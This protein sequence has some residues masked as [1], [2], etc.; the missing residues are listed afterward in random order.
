MHLGLQRFGL[1]RTRIDAGGRLPARVA[2]C[3]RPDHGAGRRRVIRSFFPLSGR[4]FFRR[5][6]RR[7]HG[8]QCR[9]DR[10]GIDHRWCGRRQ[11]PG[12][13]LRRMDGHG[14][15]LIAVH[16][17]ADGKVAGRSDGQRAG[18]AAGRT[19]RSSRLGASR[20]R[21]DQ[22]RR[23]RLRGREQVKTFK[24][25]QAWQISEGT[26]RRKS[27]AG[28]HKGDEAMQIHGSMLGADECAPPVS[29]AYEGKSRPRSRS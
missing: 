2:G 18:R 7:R 23:R 15:R 8:Q 17:I 5:R 25:R 9:K 12:G 26:A 4:P 13:G 14:L 28:C 19:K 20:V 24:I 11:E 16:C 1:V 27:G 29:V 21:L 3:N 10:I 6:L 22:Y